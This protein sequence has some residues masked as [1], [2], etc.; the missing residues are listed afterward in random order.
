MSSVEK[1]HDLISELVRERSRFKTAE[2]VRKLASLAN[3]ER[4]FGREYHGRFVIELLQNAADAWRKVAQPNQRSTVRIVLGEGPSL[5]VANQGEFLSA[6]TIIK[7]L[8]HIGASTKPHGE[9]IG[10]KGIG[11]KSVLEMTLS[12]EIYSGWDDSEFAVAVRFDP[13]RALREIR[14]E[15]PQWDAFLADV[16]GLS[17]DP[18]EPIP[19]LQ[20]P[21]RVEAVPA[22]VIE[23]GRNGFTTIVRLVFDEAHAERLHLDA[24]G[25]EQT[26][27][28]ALDDVTDKIVLLLDMFDEVVLD[29]RLRGDVAVI[30]Q[31]TEEESRLLDGRVRVSQLIMRRNG[32]LSSRWRLYRETLPSGALLEGEIVAGIPL[33]LDAA[34]PDRV[35]TPDASAP[36]HLF[37]PTRIAS[38]TP[39]LL[40]GYF[41]VAAGRANF[42]G[43]SEDRNKLLLERLSVLVAQAVSDAA[44]T[45]IDF[46]AL[47]HLL[48]KAAAPEDPLARWFQERAL[49]ALDDVA[50]VPTHPNDL[51]PPMVRPAEALAFAPASITRRLSSAFDPSYIWKSARAAAVSDAVDDVGL[52]YL[53]GRRA[54]DGGR[55]PDLWETLRALFRPVELS[56]WPLGQEDQG[57]VALL[58]LLALLDASDRGRT[59]ALIDRLRGDESARL[60]PTV[61]PDGARELVPPPAL[62]EGGRTGRTQLILARLRE[63]EVGELIPPVE[64]Q[65]S[66]IADQLFDARLL[67]GPGS[68]LGVQEYVVD[69]IIDRLDGLVLDG[70]TGRAV[71]DFMWR[72]L[73]REK[74][75]AFGLQRSLPEMAAFDPG[76]WFWFRRGRADGNE[77]DRQRRERGLASLP[78]PSRIGTWAPASQLAFG[79]DW[80][81]WL[82]SGAVG[83]ETAAIRQ[84]AAAYRDLEQLAPS[85]E[86]LL[87]PPEQIKSLL[88]NIPLWEEGW[89]DELAEDDRANLVR[90]GFLLRLGV[91]EVPPVEVFLDRR[92]RA[93]N[94]IPWPGPLCDLLLGWVAEHGGWKFDYADYEHENV[95][96]GEDYRFEW[97]FMGRDPE[98]LA[99]SI[100]RASKLYEQL[101]TLFAFCSGCRTH[102][103]RYKTSNGAMFPS[104]LALQ[105]Q[106]EPWLPCVRDGRD[107]TEA[108]PPTVAWWDPA[109][110]ERSSIQQSPVRYLSIVRASARIS[111]PLRELAEL[112]QLSSAPLDRTIG[113]LADLR[114]G[115]LSETLEPEPGRSGSGEAG[116][117]RYSSGSHTGDS[118]TSHLLLRTKSEP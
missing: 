93:D 118:L 18:L 57:F 13:E 5:I 10:Y 111:E 60:I 40:H 96:I 31:E 65:V 90:H 76:R 92:D 100:A 15:S 88:P 116:I 115:F 6:E 21:F 20:F 78:L 48:G 1:G 25:W 77:A 39:F 28:R 86:R 44:T 104:R 42:Y 16:T 47:A 101:D 37:F 55:P 73:V 62:A 99:R 53:A 63:R 11:F 83:P 113:L 34:M 46:A 103:S 117:R 69:N 108:L 50:W 112:P 30:T 102:R 24:Q 67:A 84:R 81:R 7:S 23:L 22:E 41:E 52:D 2:D 72:L 19:V 82:E 32:D 58:E 59:R 94:R 70:T 87:A 98:P 26:A 61:A 68:M 109:P 4:Q 80:A 107:I 45:G 12:P 27:R 51:V 8:G 29:D 66:F 74:R 97:T 35:E 9:A 49:A 14:S 79:E 33:S 75:S 43:G 71:V 85:P 106:H 64:L 110:P 54:Q 105:L 56:P 36:F 17:G 38:G 95:T 91:W 3:A 89:S 114:D